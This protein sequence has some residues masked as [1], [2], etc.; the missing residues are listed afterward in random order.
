MTT[1]GN[2]KRLTS[3]LGNHLKNG[4]KQFRKLIQLNRNNNRF[5]AFAKTAK[6]SFK[7]K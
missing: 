1:Q 6:E 5:Q 3:T 2:Q 7:Q 4:N